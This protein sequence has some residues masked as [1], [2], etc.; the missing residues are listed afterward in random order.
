MEAVRF[1]KLWAAIDILEAQEQLAALSVSVYPSLNKTAK[2]AKVKELRAMAYPQYIYKKQAKDV[3][4]LLGK[5]GG[6][7]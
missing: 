1:N 4:Y 3:K 7:S 5:L 2:N 6:A